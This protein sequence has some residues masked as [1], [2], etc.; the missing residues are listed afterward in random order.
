MK[1]TNP[2][3]PGF[4]PD[5]SICK[6]KD[7][8]YMVHSTFQYFP[9]VTLFE[10]KDLI[11]WTQIG[12][13]LTRESQLPLE[14]AGRSGGIYAPTIRCHNGRFYM[15]T[16]NVSAFGNFYVWTD[17]IY[18]EWSEPVI[19]DQDGIDPSLYFEDN[20]CYFMSNGTDEEGHSGIIQCE[21]DIETGKKLTPG[22]CIWKGTGGRYLEAPHLYKIN[23]EYY[24]LAAEGGTEYGHFIICAKGKTPYGPFIDAPNNPILTNR[25]LGGYEIQ[26]CGHGDLIEDESG[27]W[28]MV[29]LAFRQIGLWNMFHITGRETCLVPVEFSEDGWLLVGEQG[30][31]PIEVE[32][33]RLPDNLHQDKRKLYTIENTSPGIEWCFLRA[34]DMKKYNFTGDTIELTA[35]SKKLSDEYGSPTFTCIRQCE[36]VG[37]VSCLVAL[38]EQ[39]A[40]ITLYMDNMHHYDFFIKKT[41]EG[42]LI[43]KRICIGD[44]AYIQES[45]P[46]ENRD[47]A[48]VTLSIRMT[49]TNYFFEAL[50]K[51]KIYDF[52]K[53]QTRYLS[54][55]VAEG[56]TGVMIGLYA[57]SDEEDCVKPAIFKDFVYDLSYSSGE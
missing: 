18:G 5:P 15:V 28:W 26:G 7:I 21:I 41:K 57:Q 47:I 36:M 4:Y 37:K 25:N 46:I 43:Q 33:D 39:E 32:T 20:I 44:I 13:V 24:I 52:G 8:Y 11:N 31:T 34:P 10:S 22:R 23:G 35:T 12:H 49:P 6:Y 27:N 14:K 19:V 3:I 45:I 17:D 30:T 1:Y 55:E 56:F 29:H 48:E 50:Y 53:N 54:T 42:T 40:G 16:T 51:D 38:E 9:G 2:I